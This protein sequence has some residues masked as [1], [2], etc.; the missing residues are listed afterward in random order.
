MPGATS[1]RYCFTVNNPDPEHSNGE[2]PSF[3]GLPVRGCWWQAEVG[4]LAGTLHLQGYVELL[5]PVRLSAMRR[6]LPTAHWEA[7]RG[8]REQCIDYCSKEHSRVAGPWTLGDVAAGRR[9]ST[10]A[11][12]AWMWAVMGSES[13]DDD[14]YHVLHRHFTAS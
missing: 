10:P 2:L 9:E 4:E 3:D 6:W 1:R 5:A 11:E 14:L 12:S 13:P 8:T 7:A